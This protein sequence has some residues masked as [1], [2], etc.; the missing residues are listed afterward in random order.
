MLDLIQLG[1][2]KN[3][4]EVQ[5]LN[6]RRFLRENCT[7]SDLWKHALLTS[8]YRSDPCQELCPS[9]IDLWEPGGWDVEVKLELLQLQSGSK[10]EEWLIDGGVIDGGVIDEG[11]IYEGVMYTDL[12]CYSPYTTFAFHFNLVHSRWDG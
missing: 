2:F 5:Y 11:V 9:H 6:K 8:L 10:L 1:C 7:G 4:E 3:V 12:L